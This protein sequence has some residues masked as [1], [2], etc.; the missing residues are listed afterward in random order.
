MQRL[1]PCGCG[2][3]YYSAATVSRQLGG[4]WCFCAPAAVA[5]LPLLR[6]CM[7]SHRRRAP[8]FWRY[9][10]SA[11]GAQP[12]SAVGV[13]HAGASI[14]DSSAA[15]P[16]GGEPE[17]A[18]RRPHGGAFPL[19]WAQPHTCCGYYSSSGLVARAAATCLLQFRAAAFHSRPPSRYQSRDYGVSLSVHAG[20]FAVVRHSRS[21]CP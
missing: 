1:L 8:S 9:M 5:A 4:N 6:V 18:C 12:P 13:H 11:L 14:V 3:S 19:L 2:R 7:P 10:G 15:C 16:Q 20:A 17:V 21:L